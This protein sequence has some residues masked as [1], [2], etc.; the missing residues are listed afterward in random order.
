MATS[1]IG[2]SAGAGA[3]ASGVSRAGKDF[4]V[5]LG[6]FRDRR[7]A[8]ETARRMVGRFPALGRGAVVV[9]QLPTR[10]RLFAAQVAGLSRTDAQDAC[11]HLRQRRE[12]C[13]VLAP[14]GR[15][16]GSR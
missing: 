2:S 4:A 9:V 15:A 11:A 3:A 1:S 7:S 13:L 8:A 14:T 10:K 16:M 6:A 12:P 5:Q